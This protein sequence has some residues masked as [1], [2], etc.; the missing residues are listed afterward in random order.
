[1]ENTAVGVKVRRK[2][3]PKKRT[4]TVE[5]VSRAL[6]ADGTREVQNCLVR[7]TKDRAEWHESGQLEG[8]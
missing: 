1:M 6:S 4:G 5:K 8:V 7:Y 2:E 3:D